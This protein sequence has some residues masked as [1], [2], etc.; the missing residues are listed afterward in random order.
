[1]TFALDSLAAEA[2]LVADVDADGD[3]DLLTRTIGSASDSA[4]WANDGAGFLSAALAL[5]GHRV[6]WTG[7]V[8]LDGVIDLLATHEI[9]YGSELGLLLG[10]QG[11]PGEV[12]LFTP[13][14][15]FATGWT[16]DPIEGGIDEG[17]YYLQD[18]FPDIA[19]SRT[20]GSFQFP[21]DFQFFANYVP[22][23]TSLRA[24]SFRDVPDHAVLRTRLG[25]VDLDGV[26]DALAGPVQ[27][28]DELTE[29]SQFMRRSG[30]TFATSLQLMPT[31]ELVDLD[32]DGDLDVL[33]ERIVLNRTIP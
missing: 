27:G 2:S 24:V 8:D 22:H 11:A 3:L 12:P 7:D 14:P 1:M 13:D 15:M 4:L 19:I 30:I 10:A 26:S 32:M 17:D 25:D 5:P 9:W 31:G 33:A 20:I 16:F 23:G 28:E 29:L 21:S 18:G 6:A